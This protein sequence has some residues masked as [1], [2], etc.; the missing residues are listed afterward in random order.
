[1][2]SLDSW[3]FARVRGGPTFKNLRDK[4]GSISWA[5]SHP[6]VIGPDPLGRPGPTL[7]GT[8]PPGWGNKVAHIRQSL[9]R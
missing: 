7:L 3:V 9:R 8:T 1:M 2:E 4:V 5:V 6:S